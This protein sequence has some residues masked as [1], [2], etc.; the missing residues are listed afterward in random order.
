MEYIARYKDELGNNHTHKFF[1]SHITHAQRKAQGIGKSNGWKF[2][3]V[4]SI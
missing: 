4:G 1:A 2:I 3:S